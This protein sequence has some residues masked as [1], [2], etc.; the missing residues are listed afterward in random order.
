MR[1]QPLTLQI[2][3]PVLPRFHQQGTQMLWFL[4]GAARPVGSHIQ[5]LKTFC[6]LMEG[7]MVSDVFHGWL[8]PPHLAPVLVVV[9]E[10]ML[11]VE[12]MAG[13]ASRESGA[14]V[15]CAPYPWSLSLSIAHHRVQRFGSQNPQCAACAWCVCVWKGAG[16]GL[17]TLADTLCPMHQPEVGRSHHRPY[18]AIG[19]KRRVLGCW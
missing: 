14:D 18:S 13:C 15:L 17:R 3:R 6:V 5:Y 12:F 10:C 11:R 16:G 1:S 7:C 19:L 2:R 4:S 8:H 9:M